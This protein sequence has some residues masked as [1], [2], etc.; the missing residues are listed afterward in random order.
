MNAKRLT[1]QDIADE[2][3]VSLTAA[4]LYINGKARRYNLAEATCARIQQVLDAHN[5]IPNLHARAIASKKTFLVGVII[6]Q[7]LESS[8]WLNILS[9]LETALARSSYHM[10]LS[11]SR[12]DPKV[13]AESIRF[14][15]AKGVDG[16]IINPVSPSLKTLVKNLPT[17]T[18]NRPV[19]GIPGVWNDNFT[20]GRKAAAFLLE[21][22]HRRIAYIGGGLDRF[23]AFEQLMRENNLPVRTFPSVPGFMAHAA[24][25]TAVFCATDYILLELYQAAAATGLKIPEQLSAIGYDNMEFL[26]LLNP[27]PATISQYKNELGTA[28]GELILELIANPDSARRKTVFEPLL[29][30]GRSVAAI[31]P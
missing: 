24:D 14:M 17:A 19:E 2:A 11:V 31:Q 12:N 16:L 10:L 4:S 29:V 27:P 1:L 3:G 26:K 18:L 30:P 21:N 22:G 25:F 20:G 8:F 9:G 28:A 13:E 5:F 7:E 15:R 6:S 23:K